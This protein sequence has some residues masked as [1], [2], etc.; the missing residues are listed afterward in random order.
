MTMIYPSASFTRPANTT[1]YTAGDLVANDA[2]AGNVTPITFSLAAA[3]G[4][5]SFL[6]LGAS[7]RKSSNVVTVATFA[8][9]L[10]DRTKTVVGG[11][12]ADFEVA[13]IDGYLG[14]IAMDAATGATVGIATADNL[15]EYYSLG[16]SPLPI[17]AGAN[18]YGFLA[19]VG[20]YT[21]T[22]AEVFTLRLAL[23][24]V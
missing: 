18:I 14:S 15:F 5:T 21:P 4:R 1:Q 8:L 7:L 10:F 16:A 23:Q 6:A 17:I 11:D 20:A 13:T 12:N 9:H 19:A 2:T 22:S 24:V 3:A